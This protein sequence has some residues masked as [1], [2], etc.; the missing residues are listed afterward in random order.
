[1]AFSMAWLDRDGED[2][3][4]AERDRRLLAGFR[5]ELYR[6][7]T[8]RADALS[9]VADAVLCK[10]DRVH[11]L[12]ELCLEPECRRGHGAVF[13]AVNCG[14]VSF[15]RLRRALAALPLPAWAD[16]R[17]R[18]AADVSNW[19]RPDAQTCPERLFCHT[20]PRGKGNAQMIPGWPYSFIVAL[21]PGRTSWTRPLDAIRPG[22]ADDA[23]E[24]TAAQVREVTGR[25]IAAGHWQEGDP[26]IIVVFDSGYDLTR[27]AWLLRDLPVEVLGRLRSDRVMYFPAPERG[28]G[29]NGRPLRHGAPLKL[30]D[31][32]TWPDAAV[33]TI[34][35]TARY[36]TAQAAAW[37]RMHQRLT[38][39][40]GWEQH[41]GDL[42]VIEGTLIRL[43]VDHLPGSRNADPVWLWT[44]ASVLDEQAVNRTW[45]A[46]LRR[47]DIEHTFRF[48]KQSLGWTR[49]RLR[50]PAAADRWTWLIIACYTQLWL[51]RHLAADL[52]LPWQ[53]PSPPGR[54]TPA[55]V[56]QGFRNIR[57]TMPGLASAPKPGT[58]GPGRPPGSKNR[59]PATRHDVGKTVKRDEHKDAARSQT[60]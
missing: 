41:D 54:L 22:P 34:T 35:G 23:T 26:A 39:R 48:L 4:G 56:R 36:G 55:R 15:G 11:M 19:L 40:A 31:Q 1:V 12:A 52:R 5:G 18:L 27:L 16:G 57:Q 30:A 42:P 44:T 50:D 46:F 20:Y 58:P 25:L 59:H 32:A 51:A 38:S 29:T 43:Q 17:I 24:V 9:E 45:Q 49:P 37:G 14:R 33:T 6:C 13:D 21:E 28:P 47:F 8:R 3:D 53:Q 60:G 10:P 7:L 2:A